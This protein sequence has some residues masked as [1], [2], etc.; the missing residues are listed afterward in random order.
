MIESELQKVTRQRDQLLEA[1]KFLLDRFQNFAPWENALE[2]FA[3]QKAQAAIKAVE[4]N[5]D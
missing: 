3:E 5:H 2:R 4:E 1:L